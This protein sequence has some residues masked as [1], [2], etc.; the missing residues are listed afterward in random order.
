MA[1]NQP[2]KVTCTLIVEVAGGQAPVVQ[3]GPTAMKVKGPKTTDG[4][5]DLTID[6]PDPSL[7]N[8]TLSFAFTG[9]V[10]PYCAVVSGTMTHTACGRVYTGQ[11]PTQSGQNTWQLTFGGPTNPLISGQY[12]LN[13][14]TQSG[15]LASMI[16]TV[17][18]GYSYSC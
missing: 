4:D 10:S 3:M 14:L 6:P 16:V 18:N 13:V 1:Q 2:V 17:A 12:V 5:D 15:A 11:P 9:E 8:T 7:P